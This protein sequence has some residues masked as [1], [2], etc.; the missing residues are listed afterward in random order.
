MDTSSGGTGEVAGS[1]DR[2]SR[3]VLVACWGWGA[4]ICISSGSLGMGCTG[5][6]VLG[7]ST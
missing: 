2:E 3:A 7:S 1:A 5:G 4:G 6:L